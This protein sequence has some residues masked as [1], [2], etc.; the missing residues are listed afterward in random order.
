MLSL[1]VCFLLAPPSNRYDSYN[2]VGRSLPYADRLARINREVLPLYH[3][4]GRAGGGAPNKDPKGHVV[5]QIQGNL[6]MEVIFPCF[7]DCDVL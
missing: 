3:P 2:D 5:T 1:L 7:R 6:N 4:F